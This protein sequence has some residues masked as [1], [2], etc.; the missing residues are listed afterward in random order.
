MSKH[1]FSIPGDTRD[2]LSSQAFAYRPI[3]PR[4]VRWMQRRVKAVWGWSARRL[5]ERLGISRAHLKR[6][7]SGSR[8]V[9]EMV[10]VRFRSLERDL[11]EHVQHEQQ[12]SR[13]L[14]TVVSKFQLPSLFEI[15]AKPRKCPICKFHF[16]PIVG[17]QKYCGDDCKRLARKRERR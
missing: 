7:E 5:A 13:D 8:G 16:V 12:R 3:T 17:H 6:I 11:F 10:A 9:S 15:L 2:K 4:R 1:Q 14:K